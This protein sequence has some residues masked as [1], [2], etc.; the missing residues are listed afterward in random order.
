MSGRWEA[1]MFIANGTVDI[2]GATYKNGD[3]LPESLDSETLSQW[4]EIGLVI[5][6][7]EE[8][9]ATAGNASDEEAAPKSKSRRKA[10]E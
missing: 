2:D 10:A 3:V 1:E 5:S 8:S 6:V 7:P 4:V 9:K